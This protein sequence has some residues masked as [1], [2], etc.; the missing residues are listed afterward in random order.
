MEITIE[1]LNG[2]YEK[3]LENGKSVEDFIENVFLNYST[4]ATDNEIVYFHKKHIQKKIGTDFKN[5]FLI[6]SRHLGLKISEK[7]IIST[8]IKSDTDYDYAVV[9]KFLFSKYFDKYNIS[10]NSGKR[11]SEYNIGIY[12]KHFCNGMLHPM[13]NKEFKEEMEELLVGLNGKVSVCIYL[14]EKS[15]SKRLSDY[16][17]I[18]LLKKLGEIKKLEIVK[19]LK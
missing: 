13:Y 7:E 2:I 16:Y 15:F 1:K 11:K 4:F 10:V 12:G 6:G 17:K 3:I 8:E 14:S 5:I 19:E 18:P 9:D